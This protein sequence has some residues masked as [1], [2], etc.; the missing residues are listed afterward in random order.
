MTQRRGGD[1]RSEKNDEQIAHSDFG[2]IHQAIKNADTGA[3]Q[4][5]CC[6]KRELCLEIF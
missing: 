6:T 4:V 5:L 1:D 3:Y 2:R